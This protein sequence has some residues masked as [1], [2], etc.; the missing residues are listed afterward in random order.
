MARAAGGDGGVTASNRD[1]YNAIAAHWDVARRG[2]YGREQPYL[3]LVLDGLPEFS[4]ILDLGCGTGRPM[5]EY[6]VARGHRVTGVDQAEALLAIA[7]SH[8][9][10]ESWI[11]ARLE[12]FEPEGCYAG[13]MCW[14][15]LFHI[16][17]AHHAAIVQRVGD[18]LLPGSKLMLTVGGSESEPFE[19]DMFGERFFYDSHAPERALAMVRACGLEV[20]LGEFMNLPTSGRDKGRYAIVARKPPGKTGA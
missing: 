12:G 15:A 9:P 6:V 8:L 10:G 17:R 19:D 18:A 16:P 5:A 4:R 3:D 11:E 1:A 7:R 2:F 14:D 20:V 13:A